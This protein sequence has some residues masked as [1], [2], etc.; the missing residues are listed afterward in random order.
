MTATRGKVAFDARRDWILLLWIGP[1]GILLAA[2]VVLMAITVRNTPLGQDFLAAFPGSSA[3]P[4]GTPVGFPTWLS[5]THA[6]NVLFILMII[7][8]GLLIRGGK[9]PDA[10]VTSKRPPR[11]GARPRRISITV[12]LHNA[13]DIVWV[14]NGF[15]YVVLLFVSGQWLR[16]VPTSWDVVPNAISAALQYASLNWPTENG[17]TNYNGLQLLAYFVT[18]FIASPLAIVT[19]WRMSVLWP[20]E[21]WPGVAPRLN[22]MFPVEWARAIHFPVM[23]YFL[24]FILAHVTL[25][26]ATGFLRNLNHMYGNRDEESWFG[27]VVFSVS[28]VAMIAVWIVL[29]PPIVRALAGVT[30]KVVR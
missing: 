15:V 30:H 4:E 3:I 17:W 6:L 14:I 20:G 23:L 19:G 5:W 21:L 12:W 13:F 8:T 24:L 29:R 22:R 18:V 26:V 10:F 1:V 25:V 9:R 27:L 7:R 11:G 16:I 28:V 2:A